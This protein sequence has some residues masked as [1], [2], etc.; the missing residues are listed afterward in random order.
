MIPELSTDP[1]PLVLSINK[2]V[3][4]VRRKPDS[5]NSD[6]RV[7]FQR[8]EELVTISNSLRLVLGCH[9]R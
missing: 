1:A 6:Q 3:V 5:S 4:E 8:D 7:R 2:Q 9:F